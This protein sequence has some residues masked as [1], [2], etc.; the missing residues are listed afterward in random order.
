MKFVGGQAQ[1]SL[2][3][4]TANPFLLFSRSPAQRTRVVGGDMLTVMSR[5]LTVDDKTEVLQGFSLE[6]VFKYSGYF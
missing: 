3:L 6:T 2:S 4:S 1:S 5:D